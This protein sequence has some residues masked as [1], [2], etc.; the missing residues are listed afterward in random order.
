MRHVQ[1]NIPAIDNVDLIATAENVDN[2]LSTKLEKAVRVVNLNIADLQS[3]TIDGLPRA[4]TFSN[5]LEAKVIRYIDSQNIV[6]GFVNVYQKCNM[7][8]QK[9]I[10]LCYLKGMDNKDVMNALGYEHSQYA[11]IKQRAL[12]EFADRFEMQHGCPDLHAYKKAET[13]R[14]H[15]GN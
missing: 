3:P 1:L 14:K 13:Y 6:I 9:I 2:F 8:S 15:T 12:N 10:R 4:A 11:I 7:I 5:T